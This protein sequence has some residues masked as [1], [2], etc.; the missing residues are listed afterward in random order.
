MTNFSTSWQNS[1]GFDVVM[2]FGVMMN[3]L[4]SQHT[5]DIMFLTSWRTFWRRHIF[6]VTTHFLKSWR[7][8]HHDVFLL[9]WFFLDI[10]TWFWRHDKLFN[11]T[12]LFLMS[13]QTSWRQDSLFDVTKHFLTS[14]RTFW[15]HDKLFKDITLFD[16]MIN[17]MCFCRHD[18]LFFMFLMSSNV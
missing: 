1:C 14:W 6:D 13:W 11:D 5:F 2:W 16:V 10:M 9:S 15:R 3:F 18:E 4:T 17:L 8:W 12:T 7:F